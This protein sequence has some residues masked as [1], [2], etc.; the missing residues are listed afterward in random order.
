VELV[1]VDCIVAIDRMSRTSGWGT[2][3]D[4][5]HCFPRRDFYERN[6][7]TLVFL[8]FCLSVGSDR[9]ARTRPGLLASERIL[10]GRKNGVW[11]NRK[12][13]DPGGE[14]TK[15]WVVACEVYERKFRAFV[16][17]LFLLERLRAART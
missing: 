15:K 8:F 13:K 14:G 5:L 2:E 12:R 17:F 11:S 9:A 10:A 4:P 16:F 6:N 3:G 1:R 7:R